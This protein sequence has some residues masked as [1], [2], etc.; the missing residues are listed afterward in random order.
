MNKCYAEAMLRDFNN[1]LVYSGVGAVLCAGL[2]L[3]TYGTLGWVCAIVVG[4]YA[5]SIQRNIN[6]INYLKTYCRNNISYMG[7]SQAWNRSAFNY[8]GEYRCY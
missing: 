2:G 4:A 5:A 3:A 6:D 1:G 8:F 7:Y